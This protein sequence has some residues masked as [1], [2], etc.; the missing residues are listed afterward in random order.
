MYV[1]P[2]AILLEANSES[3]NTQSWETTKPKISLVTLH[4]KAM[5]FKLGC[6]DI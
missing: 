1:I 2:Q 5:V 6:A 3:L 4:P